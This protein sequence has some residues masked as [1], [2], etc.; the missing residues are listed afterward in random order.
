MI[1]QFRLFVESSG[2][3]N[4]FNDLVDIAKQYDYD[5]F[6][7]KTDDLA[8]KYNILYRGMDDS[9]Y[10]ELSDNSFMTD[11]IGHAR[12]YGEYVDGVIVSNEP[13]LYFDNDE[14][15]NLRENFIPVILP[16]FPKYFDNYDEY[17]EEIKE[18]LKKIYTP[19]FNENKLGDAMYQL[20]YSE[21][22]VIDFVY[23][24]LV[25]SAEKYK[26]YSMSK[27][28]DFFIP[29][30]IFYAKSRGYNIISFWGSD[31]GGADE[32]VIDDM[33]RYTKLSDIWKSVN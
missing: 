8:S 7:N 10:D 26:K 5:A 31:F 16:T 12:E 1:K 18:A 3:D 9:E 20:D 29:L 15:D 17:Q 23:D 28:N 32:F 14:F 24:I 27:K 19:Y 2:E 21:D 22:K 13:I 6:L 11:W 30:L 25:N 33:S 4:K